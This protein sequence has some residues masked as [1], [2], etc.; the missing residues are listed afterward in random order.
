MCF[1]P[2]IFRRQAGFPSEEAGAPLRNSA[3]RRNWLNVPSS[4]LRMYG[5]VNE[6]Y[7][8]R[9]ELV[10][11]KAGGAYRVRMKNAPPVMEGRRRGGG[12]RDMGNVLSS[13]MVRRRSVSRAQV[14]NAPQ[15]WKGRRRGGGRDMGNVLSSSMVGRRSA[16]RAQVKN[17]P[18]PLKGRRRGGVRLRGTRRIRL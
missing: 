11:T 3:V 14:K 17:A 2:Y 13:S 5:F 12:G 1:L 16:S 18:Q 7:G 8:E 4:I 10:G 9:F 6:R 15:P